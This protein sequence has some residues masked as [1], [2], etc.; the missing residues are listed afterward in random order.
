M[1]HEPNRVHAC[2]QDVKDSVES[3]RSA[4][5]KC[6][7]KNEVTSLKQMP[8]CKACIDAPSFVSN[9]TEIKALANTSVQPRLPSSVVSPG[10]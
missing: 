8:S 1:G 7:L 10:K 9:A 3:A 4:T 2:L 5:E 6:C